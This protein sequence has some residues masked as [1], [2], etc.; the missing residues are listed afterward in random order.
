MDKY[1]DRKT[2][3][4]MASDIDVIDLTI[5]EHLLKTK[6]LTEVQKVALQRMIS[7]WYSLW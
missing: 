4:V 5:L 1:T 3:F 7:A 6:K 2:K